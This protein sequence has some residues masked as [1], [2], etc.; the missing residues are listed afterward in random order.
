MAQLDTVLAN[1]VTPVLFQPWNPSAGR[2]TLTVDTLKSAPHVA[3]LLYLIRRHGPRAAARLV[4]TVHARYRPEH[5]QDAWLTGL[6][7]LL[8]SISREHDSSEVLRISSSPELTA[9]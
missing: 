1:W 2:D 3:V 8:K 7:R 4:R 9:A 5:D 6:V